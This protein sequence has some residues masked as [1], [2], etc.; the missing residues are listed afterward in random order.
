[1]LQSASQ[2]T[3]PISERASAARQ[4]MSVLIYGT[5][6][7][8]QAQVDEANRRAA[9]WFAERFANENKTAKKQRSVRSLARRMRTAKF[10]YGEASS[11]YR[12]A[13][14]K[15]RRLVAELAVAKREARRC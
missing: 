13:F 12:E 2:R 14:A 8:T 5:P 1:M 9:E 4:R 15:H 11:E 6:T 7:P 3:S 10:I